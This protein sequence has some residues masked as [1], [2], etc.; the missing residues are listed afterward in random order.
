MRKNIFNET[1]LIGIECTEGQ[2]IEDKVIRIAQ[3][4]EP[5]GE[6]VPIIFTPR[7][8]GVEVQYNVRTDRFDI[9][10]DAM[11]K[12]DKS[13]KARRQEKLKPDA[14]SVDEIKEE[15]QPS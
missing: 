7:A 1:N 10:I 2:R 3:N 4:K 11:S 12:V 15:S 5:I 13:I 6:S 9:A 14:K 8:N